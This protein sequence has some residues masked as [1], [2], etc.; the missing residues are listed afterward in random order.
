MRIATIGGGP[1]GHYASLLLKRSSPE[2]DVTVFEK[3][4]R[5][6]TYGWGVVFSDRTLTSFREADYKSYVDITDHFVI[7]D[8]IDIR[9]KDA[10]MRA[11]GQVFSGIARRRLLDILTNRCMEVGVDVRFE[12]EV[13][14]ETLGDY[15]L[16]IAADGIHSATRAGRPEV[17]KPRIRDGKARYIWFG[18]KLPLDSFTFIFRSNDDGL[19]QV[20]AYPFD[21]TTSTFIVEC[22]EETWRKAGLH[23]ASEAESIAYCEKLFADDLRGN[24]LMSNQS[25]WISFPTLKTKAW[26]DAGRE[27]VPIALLGDSAHTAH[28]S[29]GSGTKLA[30]EDAI[31]LANAFEE[32]DAAKGDPVALRTALADYQMERKPIV[33]RFQEAAQQSQSYFESTSRY[34]DLEPEQFVFHLLTRSGRIDYGHLRQ[35][36]PFLIEH[37]DRRFAAHSGGNERA[38]VAPPPALVPFDLGG[39]WLDNR[40]VLSPVA[41]GSCSGGIIAGSDRELLAS[42]LSASAGLVLTDEIAVS[43]H[44]RITSGDAGL[45][46]DHQVEAFK[47]LLGQGGRVAVR[48]NHAGARGATKPRVTGPDRPLDSGGWPL[49]AASPLAYGRN[50]TPNPLDARTRAEILEDFATAAA[51][52]GRVGFDAVVVEMGRGYLLGGFLSPLTNLRTDEL[53]GDALARMRFPLEVFDAV[54]AEFEG[55]VGASICADDWQRGGTKARDALTLVLELRARDCALVEVTAGFTT[56]RFTPHLDP[57]YLT[58]LS[59]QIRN[60]SGMPTLIGGGITTVDRINTLLGGARADLCI[61]RSH[62]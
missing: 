28:F 57:Y 54:R 13:V 3:N 43:A 9:Y 8:A 47:D 38:A 31:A 17:F 42:A 16:V 1:G 40:V 15:D 59:E 6:A 11:G 24:P 19:F 33:E 53:G 14:A 61:L 27:A 51:N 35:S 30:M 50:A 52:A 41:S 56:P 23:E 62:P 26:I 10:L 32:R 12:T 4:P 21:G 2:L 7:W 58:V 55:P 18:T 37:V 36:D 25:Q 45:Y 5:G 49:V 46:D 48:L 29:I 20:H 34:Q 44:G 60:E 39:V 22:N